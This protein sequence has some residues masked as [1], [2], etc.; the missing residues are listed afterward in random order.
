MFDAIAN[1]QALL[2]QW[3]SHPAQSGDGSGDGG[4]STAAGGGYGTRGLRG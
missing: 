3:G 4:N 1:C 2:D